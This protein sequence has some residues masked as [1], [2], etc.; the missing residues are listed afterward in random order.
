MPRPVQ[1][2]QR[3]VTSRGTGYEVRSRSGSGSGPGA[4]SRQREAGP[5][6]VLGSDVPTPVRYVGHRDC[7]NGKG[8]QLFI[9]RAV[10]DWRDVCVWILFTFP[11]SL[12]FYLHIEKKIDNLHKTIFGNFYYFQFINQVRLTKLTEMYALINMLYLITII[13]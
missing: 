8:T 10:I 11:L 9:D 12:F 5:S 3:T 4:C 1:T 13:L 2:F 6:C 7:R